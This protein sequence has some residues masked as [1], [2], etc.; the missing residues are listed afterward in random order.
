MAEFILDLTGRAGLATGFA[1]DVD[2]VTSK[3]ERIMEDGAGMANGYFNQYF[4]NGYLSPVTTTSVSI[5]PSQTPSSV[6]SSVEY[7]HKNEDIYFGDKTKELYKIDSLTGTSI[8]FI[9]TMENTS[10]TEKKYDALYDLQLYELN[11]VSSLF[12]V[13]KGLSTGDGPLTTIATTPT[14]DKYVR[15]GLSIIPFAATKPAITQSNRFEMTTSSTTNTQSITVPSGTNQVLFVIAMWPSNV[16]ASSCTFG[17]VSMTS[18]GS[19][20]LGPSCRM[21]RLYNPTAST[22]NVVVTWASAVS[23]SVVYAFTTNNT[24]QTI[25][26]DDFCNRED[27]SPS[28]STSILTRIPFAS[29]N[30]LNLAFAYSDVVMTADASNGTELFNATNTYGSDL[31]VVRDETGYGLQVGYATVPVSG[32]GSTAASWLLSTAIGGF[33]EAINGDYAF[34]RTADNGFAYIFVDNRVHKIDG[35][36]TGGVDGAATQNVLLFPTNFRIT[37][38][39]DYRSNMYIAVHQYPVTVLTTSLNNYVGKVGLYVWNRISTQLSSSD[40]IELPGVREIKKIYAS[41]DGVLKLITISDNGTTELR[42]FG[43]NDSG[44]VVFPVKKRLGIGA[45]PQVPD[46]LST[47]GDKVTW[48]ANDG[49]IYC[50]KENAVTKLYQIKAQGTTTTGLAQNITTGALFYGNGDETASAGYRS[51]KQAVSFSYLDGST[52]YTKKIYPFDLKTG[53]NADQTPHQ[54]DVY[55]GVKLMP[56]TSKVN[57]IRIYN[58]PTATSDET[59]IATIKIYFN[60]STTASIPTGMTKSIT[61][62]EAKRG[63]I[64]FHINKQYI[65]AVQIE[66]EW[67]TGTPIGDDMY[68]PSLAVISYD[69]L[70]TQSPDNG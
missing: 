67:A 55:T 27:Q 66:V 45:F 1:G 30:A 32:I 14:I 23:S 21:F 60:Q 4:R 41:P 51:N 15:G 59:V 16:S 26:E 39:L 36:I 24:D 61:K 25:G 47:A 49:N 63:Y 11:G 64:D 17:G 53:A 6:F 10:F 52:V 33:T 68:M 8:T 35:T 20:Q 19:T 56:V 40:Y 70:K 46:G 2:M 28:T 7:D 50:E 69:E 31:L 57:N 5:T 44:G 54:G 13:G 3:P 38:A 34:M 48:I 43:Y 37:D 42:E 58:A 22:A 65:H 18:I 9:D 12:F 62:K 29:V